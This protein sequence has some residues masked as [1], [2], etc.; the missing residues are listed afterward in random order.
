MPLLIKTENLAITL[1]CLGTTTHPR[2]QPP[3]AVKLDLELLETN[4]LHEPLYNVDEAGQVFGAGV[5][6]RLEENRGKI[7][8]GSPGLAVTERCYS[9]IFRQFESGNQP[10]LAF[11]LEFLF[12]SRVTW[13]GPFMY[14]IPAFLGCPP[15]PIVITSLCLLCA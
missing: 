9:L 7:S 4:R 10:L 8:T 5:L 3:P 14:R 1:I 15:F 6:G 13:H 2:L 12:P 11:L